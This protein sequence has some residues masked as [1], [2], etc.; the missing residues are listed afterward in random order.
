MSSA[1]RSRPDPADRHGA[2]VCQACAVRNEGICAALDRVE[3]VDLDAI[4]S[5]VLLEPGQALFY[6]SDPAAFVFSVT[7]GCL[8]LSKLLADGRRQ[9]TGFL[10]P[11]DL[12]G[13]TFGERFAYTAEAILP[14]A[15]CRFPTEKLRALFDAYPRL[16]ARLLA[17]ACNEIVAAQDHLMLLGRMT[18]RERLLSFLLMMSRRATGRGEPASPVRLPMVRADVADYLGL[19]VEHVSRTMHALADEGLIRLDAANEISLLD[20]GRIEAVVLG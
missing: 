5:R 2:A 18:A 17:A 7:T 10:F 3:I 8:R 13:L 19:T 6:E 16:E 1:D 14:S 9:V 20:P 11:G 15:L 4:A 12:L